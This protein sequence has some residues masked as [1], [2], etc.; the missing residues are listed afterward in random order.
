MPYLER[1]FITAVITISKEFGA[2]PEKVASIT[3]KR[4][5]CQTRSGTVCHDSGEDE[6]KI[7]SCLKNASNVHWLSPLPV[8]PFTG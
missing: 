2:D 5:K 4:L 8:S 7:G 3:A 6:Q 1:S